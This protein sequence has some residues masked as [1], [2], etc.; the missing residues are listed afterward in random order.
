VD[1]PAGLRSIIRRFE[2][3]LQLRTNTPYRLLPK[4]SFPIESAADLDDPIL[5]SLLAFLALF[6]NEL[7][8]SQEALEEGEI[9]QFLGLPLSRKQSSRVFRQ[10]S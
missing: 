7:L 2:D 4:M 10:R 5:A 6:L 9:R 3:F 1:V 8:R